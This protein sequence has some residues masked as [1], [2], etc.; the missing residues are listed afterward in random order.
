MLC[1][2]EEG[3]LQRLGLATSDVSLLE[4]E[5]GRGREG[6]PPLEGGEGETEPGN[7]WSVA[8]HLL[9]WNGNGRKRKKLFNSTQ[10]RVVMQMFNFLLIRC[11]PVMPRSGE[12]LTM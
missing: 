1:A 12:T 6:L 5:G 2:G 7:T 9:S 8:L 3:E 10:R 11:E 4:K